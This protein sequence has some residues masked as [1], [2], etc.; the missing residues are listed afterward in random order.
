MYGFLL[1]LGVILALAGVLS[2]NLAVEVPQLPADKTIEVFLIAIGLVLLGIFCEVTALV[3]K[4]Q[5]KQ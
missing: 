1:W 4:P 3:V 5:N 2:I